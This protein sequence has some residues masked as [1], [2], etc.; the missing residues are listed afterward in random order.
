MRTIRA[1]ILATANGSYRP[2]HGEAARLRCRWTDAGNVRA[3]PSGIAHAQ[4]CRPETYIPQTSHRHPP[5]FTTT[6]TVSTHWTML[7]LMICA[8]V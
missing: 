1:H 3:G 7:V 5:L 6:R 8:P 4:G 2:F